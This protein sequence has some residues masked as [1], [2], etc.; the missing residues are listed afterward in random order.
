M[1]NI[2]KNIVV[3][4]TL[5]IGISY[6]VQVKGD[7]V[8]NKT[9]NPTPAKPLRHQE[10]QSPFPYNER[11]VSYENKEASVVLAGTLTIPQGNGPFPVVLL[12][13]GMGAIDR[14]GTFNDHKPLLV[15]ADHLSRQ[16]IAVLRVDKRGVGKSTGTFNFTITSGDLAA[17]VLAGIAYLKTCPDINPYKIGL[18]GISE[19]GLIA[20]MVTAQSKD[21]A[22][23]VLLSSAVANS[24]DSLVEQSATQLRFDGASAAMIE[25]DNTVRRHI[26]ELIHQ[27]GDTTQTEVQLRHLLTDYWNELSDEQKSE[28]IRLPFAFA[29]PKFDAFIGMYNSPWYRFYVTYNTS[30]ALSKMHV[31]LLALNG[32]LDFMVPQIV[33]KVIHKA[34]AIASNKDYTTIAMPNLNHA[35]QTCATGAIS[36]YAKIEETIAPIALQTI[37]EWILKHVAS[38]FQRPSG[39]YG[40]GTE[41]YG[42][43]ASQQQ[44]KNKDAL[45]PRDLTIQCWYP[46]EQKVSRPINPWAPR[47]AAF[48]EQ[49]AEVFKQLELGK[50]R[51]YAQSNAPIATDQ[52]SYPVILYSHGSSQMVGDNS[53]LCEEL[54]SHGYV[55]IG[56]DHPQE[57]IREFFS[58]GFPLYNEVKIRMENDMEQ[59]IIDAEC[60]LEYLEHLPADNILVGK[61]DLQ[62][63]GM[64]GHSFGGTVAVQLCRRDNRCKTAINME[65]PLIGKDATTPFHKPLLFLL[66]SESWLS[67][68]MT[69][70]QIIQCFQTKEN[71]LDAQQSYRTAIDV[72]ASAACDDAH[73]V[74][75]KGA[76][77]NAFVDLALIAQH[78]PIDMRSGSLDAQRTHEIMKAYVCA[79]FDKYLKNEQPTLLD[80]QQARYPEVE[81]QRWG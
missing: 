18:L 7:Y 34:M 30:A 23:A 22:F 17:D 62:N 40:V 78:S 73:T 36:E 25:K 27:N 21:V 29:Q 14:D 33:F 10:P 28:A 55:V 24:I 41:T 6:H 47:F 67:N 12:I 54:A 20:S 80:E 15:L 19:G 77:H 46:T 58:K 8:N 81:M 70:E 68:P 1:I 9:V 57:A 75:I 76:D 64:A 31:P 5:L 56:I 48:L 2:H 50:L 74:V 71:Y 49:H 61:L 45:Q 59:E 35:L 44:D 72:L 42:I 65:G 26:L 63:I 53:S 66:G 11:E 51:T 52:T 79:F 38:P 13:S 37:S 3:A 39:P 16:G 60:V 32:T 4:C 69:E 43:K